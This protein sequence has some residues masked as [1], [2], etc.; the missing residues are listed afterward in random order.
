MIL[1]L[2][3]AVFDTAHRISLAMLIKMVAQERH[4][5][6]PTMP[7]ALRAEEFVNRLDSTGSGEKAVREWATKAVVEAANP[8]PRTGREVHVTPDQLEEIVDDL[9]KP[10]VLV[11]ENRL[12]DGGF[13][14]A[15]AV[16]FGDERLMRALHPRRTWLKFCNGGGT[17]QMAKLTADE[18]A[19]FGVVMRV[20]VLFDSDRAE[21]GE[22]SPNEEKAEEA[23]QAGARHVHILTW[24]MMEN[25]VPFRVWEAVLPNKVSVVQRL[26]ATIPRQRGYLHLKHEF[27]GRRKQMPNPWERAHLGLTEADFH[28]LG[29]DVV[30]ELRR[31]LAMIH[32]IL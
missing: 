7:E 6:Y 24:R 18:C 12:G 1:D 27:V 19:G 17:G 26:R 3:L 31:I 9:V 21:H 13:I 14:R 15:V 29:P 22:P 10:A 30:N 4:E 16:A 11:V 25:Y 2:D 5:W 8:P 20:A 23:R 32:E 28:E